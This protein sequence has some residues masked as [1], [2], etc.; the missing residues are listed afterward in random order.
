MKIKE[1]LERM[2]WPFFSQ[3]QTE[4]GIRNIHP[5]L[6]VISFFFGRNNAESLTELALTWSQTTSHRS[7][8]LTFDIPVYLSYSE[9]SSVEPPAFPVALTFWSWRNDLWILNPQN[10]QKLSWTYMHTLPWV[11]ESYK[12]YTALLGIPARPSTLVVSVI[13]SHVWRFRTYL[14][15]LRKIG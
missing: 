4:F 5:L 1:S 10:N 3:P 2:G 14:A 15:L 9:Q 12:P 8:I 13:S 6:L 7:T 11:Q